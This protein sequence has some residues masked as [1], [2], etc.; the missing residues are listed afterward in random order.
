MILRIDS[1]VHCCVIFQL[2]PVF[3]KNSLE[4]FFLMFGLYVLL[5]IGL[6]AVSVR[7]NLRFLTTL[8]FI[9]AELNSDLVA[10]V[11]YVEFSLC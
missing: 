8:W 7:V 5:K 10:V 11:F 2:S 1:S 9:S 6:F 3:Q 4:I